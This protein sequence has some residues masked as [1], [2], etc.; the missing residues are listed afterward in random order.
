M[1]R[2]LAV[3]IVMLG[4]LLA[5]AGAVNAVWNPAKDW[6]ARARKH[7]ERSKRVFDRSLRAV[8]AQVDAVTERA[9]HLTDG[10]LQS[11]ATPG[12]AVAVTET[13][14]ALSMTKSVLEGLT[15]I[16]LMLFF[17]SARRFCGTHGRVTLRKG[18]FS[19]V[20]AAHGSDSGGS[21]ALLRD[22][23]AHQPRLEGGNRRRSGR[24]PACANPI[25]WGTTAGASI[26]IPYLG[27]ITTIVILE[28]AALVTSMIWD[29]RWSCPRDSSCFT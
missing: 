20:V 18:N 24:P 26:F 28:G 21:R 8:F 19:Q 9:G 17:Q 10:S 22:G 15:V 5:G 11:T 29:T 14:K 1:P 23:C 13:G 12:A 25:L 2:G 6:L 16:P 4:V 7:C 27:P 3:T